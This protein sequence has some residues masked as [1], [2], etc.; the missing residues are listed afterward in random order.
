M[1]ETHAHARIRTA[2]VIMAFVA[3]GGCSKPVPRPTGAAFEYESAKEMFQKSR[4]ERTLEF[5][6][7][8]VTASPPN[9]YT[10]RARVLRAAVLAGHVKAYTE[11]ADAYSKGSEATKNP[12]FMSEYS[13]LRHDYLQYASRAALGLGE[14]S[15]AILQ[16]TGYTPQATLEAPFP[17]AEGPLTLPALAKV[18][19]GG[20]IEPEEQESV[21][22]DALRKGIN[23]ALADL[24]GGDRSKV[25]A[26]MNEGPVEIAGVDFALYMG[27]SLLDG[28]AVFN[29]SRMRDSQ[30]LKVLAAQAEEAAKAA[31]AMLKEKPDAAKEKVVKK[32]QEDIRNAAKRL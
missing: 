10:E 26:A 27:Q 18:T 20:W 3:L 1:R 8:L 22:I 13:R 6:D 24:V 7:G 21:Q 19:E 17:S 23:E 11:L 25:R 28:A 31:A 14:L 32:L 15:H 2:V 30:K 12:R 5:T 16:S 4:F 9:A 29:R